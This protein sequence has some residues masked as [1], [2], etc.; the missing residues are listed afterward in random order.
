VIEVYCH[1]SPSGKQY[2]GYSVRG[3]AER[4]RRHVRDARR[5]SAYPFHRA[6]RKY[7]EGAFECQ[8]LVRCDSVYE[9]RREEKIWIRRLGTLVPGGYN[10]TTG[11][12]GANFCA[13]SLLKIAAAQ[14]GKR[15]SFLARL[16]MSQYQRN[17]SAEHH[18][19]SVAARRSREHVFSDAGLTRLRE[20]SA[21]RFAVVAGRFCEYRNSEKNAERL[22]QYNRTRVVS[23]ETRRKRS[24]ALKGRPVSAATRAKIAA[25]VARSWAARKAG[26]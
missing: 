3:A 15:K 18:A 9:A 16:R 12:E 19:N 23:D 5:G 24:A 17:R 10:A 20:S 2:V 21:A 22:R 13:S 25:S 8:V 4:F 1:T 11:G 14:R 6:I 7:G 26:T